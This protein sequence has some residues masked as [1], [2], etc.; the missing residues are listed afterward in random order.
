MG[1][2]PPFTGVAVNV[3][4]FPLQNTLS[5]SELVMETEA[6]VLGVTT[7]VTPVLVTLGVVIHVA[8]E[9]TVNVTTSPLI[10][11]LEVNVEAVAPATGIVLIFH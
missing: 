6:I 1:V 11:V 8:L 7:I 10:N 9:V 2:V 4:E 5:A 3:T